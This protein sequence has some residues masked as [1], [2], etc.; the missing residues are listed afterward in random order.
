MKKK[1]ICILVM[2]LL[3]ATTVLP[4]VGT[5][6]VNNNQD[7]NKSDETD[8]YSKPTQRTIKSL[9]LP[10][11]LLKLFNG[12]WDY[13]TNSPN[14]FTIPEGNVGIGTS[15]PKSELE[16]VGRI[17]A[18]GFTING[19][20]VGTSNDSYWSAYEGDLAYYGTITIGDLDFGDLNLL[21]GPNAPPGLIVKGLIQSLLGNITANNGH[22]NAGGNM[23]AGG[24]IHANGSMNAKHMNA[25]GNIHANGSMNAKGMNASGNMNAGGNIHA[26]GSMNAKGMNASGNMNAGKNINANGNI[27]ALGDL[28]VGGWIKF[29]SNFG[30]IIFPDGSR[31]YK[32]AVSGG[33]DDGDW[34]KSKNNMSAN[35]SGNV[36]IG[37][38]NPTYKLEVVGDIK[39]SNI[40]AGN[41]NIFGRTIYTNL[42]LIVGNLIE[43]I[44]TGM[45]IKFPD[46]SIQTTAAWIKSG[47][48]MYANTSIKKVGIGTIFPTKKLEVAGDTLIDGNLTVTGTINGGGSVG[49]KYLSI[50]P[51]AF[52]PY[53]S[54]ITYNFNDS[55]I[56]ITGFT[57]SV[58]TWALY[59]PVN[60]PNGSTIHEI[61]A[62]V[63]DTASD[64]VNIHLRQQARNNP[65]GNNYY[66]MN[67]LTG[68]SG[69][70]YE[71][72]KT[73][74][75]TINNNLYVYSIVASLPPVAYYEPYGVHN[76]CITYT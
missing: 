23:N 30:G 5:T 56:Q 63:K 26:N 11:W 38:T 60:L 20:P 18:D 67:S 22:I 47:D 70:Y 48:I 51:C 21:A 42:N 41:G 73:F 76:V 24:N 65:S 43:F 19:I 33:G 36:G 49:T 74:E 31:Q 46:G 1:I 9:L 53:T 40:N 6:I 10:P 27:T 59:T 4:V 37:T 32:A 8:Y 72:T 50:P 52:Q 15:N 62:M 75:L 7:A 16:V 68:Y 14:I 69:S 3:I 13:W 57:G 64:I 34:K 28:I 54:Y 71:M 58:N 2:T 44:P 25:S 55:I 17:E 29:T 45:G 66:D 61:K 35:V 39:A 12:D